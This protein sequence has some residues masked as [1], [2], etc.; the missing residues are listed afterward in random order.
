M[1]RIRWRTESGAGSRY[2]APVACPLRACRRPLSA[3]AL[4]CR[5][6]LAFTR[7][8]LLSS[9]GRDVMFRLDGRLALVTGAGQGVGMGIARCLLAQG[10]RVLVNDIDAAR[11]SAAAAALGAGAEGLAFDVT[12][13][14]AVQAALADRAVDI[15]VNN[16]GNAGAASFDQL[17]F[18]D[19][20]AA[21]WDRF[22]D[23]NLRGVMNCTKAV[24]D[25][26]C[27]RGYGRLITISSEAGRVGRNINV[28]VYG[29]AK[30]GAVQLMRHLS[31]E[32]GPSGVTANAVSLGLMNNVPAEFSARLIR[33]IPLGRLGDPADIGAAVVYLA[34]DEAAWVTGQVLVVNGGAQAG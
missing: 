8:H 4:A 24:V 13:L 15:L 11:A 12:R 25:G 19:M 23:V 5:P 6:G 30:A 32:L 3:F 16:A 27:E 2:R 17:S 22:L 18:R 1:Y 31:Q 28:S 14:A 21:Q 34:S 10:A 26:M 33:G 29:A 9:R 20:P 7:C